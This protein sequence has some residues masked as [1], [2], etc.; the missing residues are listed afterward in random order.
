MCGIFGIALKNQ[1]RKNFLEPTFKHLVEL[2]ESRGKEAS[3]VIAVSNGNIFVYKEPIP[4]SRL[5]QRRVYKNLI[6]GSNDLVI[7]HT[8]LVTNGSLE[9]NKNNQPVVKN[10]V[11]AVHNGIIVNDRAI[12]DKF[13]H[14]H[15]GLEVDTE[16]IPSLIRAFLDEGRTL[17]TALHLTYEIIE[18][19]AS[20]AVV[21]EDRDELV[22]ATNNGSLYFYRNLDKKL[23]IFASERPI[24][25]TTLERIGLA[26][27]AGMVEQLKPNWAYIL[28]I[29]DLSGKQFF[30]KSIEDLPEQPSMAKF[31]ITDYS[32]AFNQTVLT[33]SKSL[34]E[35]QFESIFSERLQR[36]K[37]LRRCKSCIMPETMPF[38]DFDNQG[39]CQYCRHYKKI[40]VRGDESLHK[41][42]EPFKNSSGRPDCLV[43]F[44]G[45]RDSSYGLHYLKNVLNMNP[46][47]YSYDWGMIT[48][49]GRRN[50]ARMC[51]KLGVEHILVS[52]DIK[53]K[54]DYI[55]KNVL[56]W[57]KKP[58][59][60]TVPLFMAGDKQFFYHANKLQKQMGIKLAV[61][62]LNPLE[63]TDFK[64]GFCGIRP[65]LGQDG[66]F[67]RHS[68]LNE[69]KLGAFYL[70]EYLRNPAYFNSS[71]WDTLGAFASYY[72]IP[73]D[74]FLLFE[75]LRWDEKT[76]NTTLQSLYN[77]EM[78]PDSTS[79]W[80]IG[81]GT[82]AFYNYIY[83]LVAG[84]TEND[85]FRSNQVREGIITREEALQFAEKENRP[86]WESLQ[87]YCDIIGID[88]GETLRIIH[89]IP[90]I[91]Q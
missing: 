87:W 54:R 67:Y 36:I 4:G 30:F 25:E 72:F 31:N 68:W 8:R 85:S 43:T 71:I 2:S 91:Y 89:T 20:I 90:T 1:S 70:K 65:T 5:I 46:V 18:G 56:A 81:D 86:R 15:R 63:R 42:L 7:G 88:L 40:E 84:F 39:I 16:V 3:G 38:I 13:P 75:Y 35:N 33:A 17:S 9:D 62:C 29:S 76:I 64:S 22:L 28:K 26:G 23:F 51:G 41:S 32:P 83:Y 82:A 45:G 34:D 6:R 61:V 80:R 24:L 14:L 47:A 49:L 12:W 53:K 21:F 57:L 55:R 11:V 58:S 59:L 37:K 50:Q 19:T 73:H 27:E 66:H 44:S 10:G 48:D 52:A 69:I 78:A 77:W 79:T 60:G 74:Q